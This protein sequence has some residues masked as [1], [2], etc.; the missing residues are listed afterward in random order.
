MFDYNNLFALQNT[1]F[2]L[3]FYEQTRNQSELTNKKIYLSLKNDQLILTNDK[4]TQI[5]S[6]VLKKFVNNLLVDDWIFGKE[7]TLLENLRSK[8]HSVLSRSMPGLSFERE[9]EVQIDQF[10]TENTIPILENNPFFDADLLVFKDNYPSSLPLNGIRDCDFYQMTIIIETLKN[11]GKYKALQI[12]LPSPLPPDF[13]FRKEKFIQ[14][15]MLLSCRRTGREIIKTIVNHP[16]SSLKVDISVNTSPEINFVSENILKYSPVAGYWLEVFDPNGSKYL[17]KCPSFIGL[18]HEMVH[19]LHFLSG[20]MEEKIAISHSESGDLEEFQTMTGWSRVVTTIDH[21]KLTNSLLEDKD[22]DLQIEEDEDLKKLWES[23]DPKS[24]NGLR[25]LYNI[26]MRSN[27]HRAGRFEE[28]DSAPVK[29]VSNDFETFSLEDLMQPEDFEQWGLLPEQNFEA[30]LLTAYSNQDWEFFDM[31]VRMGGVEKLSI[32]FDRLNTNDERLN[33]KY[34]D[35]IFYSLLR[36]NEK[37]S[38]KT[39]FR[40][41]KEYIPDQEKF[42]QMVSNQI[43]A[44]F[45]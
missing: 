41:I 28:M 24:E 1:L 20:G 27:N 38:Y 19:Y 3:S 33:R 23:W 44:F 37:T 12:L 17:N 32:L 4:T 8:L 2:V 10:F 13:E 42:Q 14:D 25:S 16:D 18:A 39:L 40:K 21:E 26:H 30:M 7:Y 29:E 11:C 6:S 34:I 45:V 22:W 5:S 15:L 9:E 36:C 43:K 35:N 31:I